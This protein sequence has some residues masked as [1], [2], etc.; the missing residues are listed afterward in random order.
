MALADLDLAFSLCNGPFANLLGAASPEAIRGTSVLEFLSPEEHR[1]TAERAERILA[2]HALCDISCSILRRDGTILPLKVSVSAVPNLEGIPTWF[3]VAARDI[4][5]ELRATQALAES[6]SRYR[7]L[8]DTMHNGFVLFEFLPGEGGAPDDFRILDANPA[9]R[10]LTG[11]KPQER[12]NDILFSTFLENRL[13]DTTLFPHLHELFCGEK[14][15][16]A[17]RTHLLFEQMRRVARTGKRISGETPLL[18]GWRCFAYTLYRPQAGRVALILEDVTERKLLE[19]NNRRLI[20]QL[21]RDASMDTLTNALNRHRFDKLLSLEM[22]RARE[23]SRPLSLVMV[24]L[25]NFKAINDS[26]GHLEGDRILVAVSELVQRHIR[27]SDIFARWGGEEFAV[28]TPTNASDA[29]TLAERLRR[30]IASLDA[31]GGMPVFASFGITQ[32]RRGESAS[33]FLNRADQALYAAKR[34]GK[35]RVEC[36]DQSTS[37]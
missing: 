30:E 24:D 1:A 33:E 10:R 21:E 35:N 29:G 2:G 26:R 23:H 9:F 12:S 20:G 32:Y 4:S 13:G 17:R 18:G 8:F 22:E 11:Q 25:D 28:L 5:E 3:L 34:K 14:G 6:E 7:S 31:G 16:L 15:D 19:E 37:R 27:S 36:L